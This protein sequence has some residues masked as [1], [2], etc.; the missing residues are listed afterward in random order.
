MLGLLYAELHYSAFS[1]IARWRKH[2]R[3][4]LTELVLEST[5]THSSEDWDISALSDNHTDN[6]S[7]DVTCTNF[8]QRL[9]LQTVDLLYQYFTGLQ[10]GL[11]GSRQTKP[12]HINTLLHCSVLTANQW[13]QL[14]PR[15][16]YKD[17]TQATTDTGICNKREFGAVCVF[18]QKQTKWN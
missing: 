13:Q 17:L 10:R 11:S 1:S 5:L 16:S 6:R 15:A 2:Y 8:T 18:R 4:D 14:H 9:T 7:D 12:P 3:P